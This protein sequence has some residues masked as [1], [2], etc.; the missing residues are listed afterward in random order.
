MVS[1]M[2]PAVIIDW[3][4]HIVLTVLVFGDGV[5]INFVLVV[6]DSLVGDRCGSVF[7]VNGGW[8]S[9]KK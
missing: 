8:F 5:E 6:G 1:E 7:V 2:V 9:Q 4:F 3:C